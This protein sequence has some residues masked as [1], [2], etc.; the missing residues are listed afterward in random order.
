[1]H[2][3]KRLQ[4]PCL[5]TVLAAFV[6][7]RRGLERNSDQFH[8]ELEGE[9]LSLPF[10]VDEQTAI[11]F[12]S[13]VLAS[14]VGTI[15]EHSVALTEA[16]V[17]QICSLLSSKDPAVATLFSSVGLTTAY[18][19]LSSLH[20]SQR[21]LALVSESNTIKLFTMVARKGGGA[22]L[23]GKRAPGLLEAF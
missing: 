1:M 15:T 20:R 19:V 21:V 11:E 6:R 10:K 16:I 17:V 3:D 14:R 4:V 23:A 5:W 22:G 7:R 18:T 9:G 8:D 2:M 13:A 12:L